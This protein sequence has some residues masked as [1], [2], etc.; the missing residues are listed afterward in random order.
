MDKI[1]GSLP[2]KFLFLKA[3]YSLGK[4][5]SELLLNVP[6]LYKVNCDTK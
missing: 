6:D 4:L 2:F 1:D 5:K 3:V